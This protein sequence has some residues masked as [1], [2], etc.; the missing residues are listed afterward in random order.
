M[1]QAGRRYNGKTWYIR[2]LGSRIS[3]RNPGR[4]DAPIAVRAK[5]LETVTLRFV[6]IEGFYVGTLFYILE[7]LRIEGIYLTDGRR[8]HAFHLVGNGHSVVI[9]NNQIYDPYAQLK[10]KEGRKFIKIMKFI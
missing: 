9:R 5:N 2:I 1:S 4:A 3:G 7:N 8:E 6:S 10:V